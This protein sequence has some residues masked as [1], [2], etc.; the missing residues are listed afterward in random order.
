MKLSVPETWKKVPYYKG[1][2]AGMIFGSGIST[3]ILGMMFQGYIIVVFGVLM[4][5]VASI[6]YYKNAT[7]E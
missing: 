5:I 1:L 4:Y 7:N 3:I 2:K 6:M